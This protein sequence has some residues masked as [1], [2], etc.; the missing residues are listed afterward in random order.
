MKE[1][2]RSFVWW[3]GLDNDIQTK[4]QSC[5]QCQ[6]NQRSPTPQPLHPWEW[7]EHPWSR[8]HIDYAGPIRNRYLPDVIDSYS[9]WLR[10]FPEGKT[11]LPGTISKEHGK[12]T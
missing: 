2:T 4:V 9:K 12:V 10:D 6:I 7:T 1:L 8:M 5:V 3:P 11:W